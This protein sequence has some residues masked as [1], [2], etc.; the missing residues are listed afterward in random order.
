MTGYD[1]NWVCETMASGNLSAD[2]ARLNRL[3]KREFPME[4]FD[5]SVPLDWLL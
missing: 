2:V 1:V 5:V 4:L 3:V